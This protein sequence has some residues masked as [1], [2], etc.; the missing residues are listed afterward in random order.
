M[1]ATLNM[2][3]GLPLNVLTSQG[4]S[5][6]WTSSYMNSP[7]AMLPVVRSDQND[8]NLRSSLNASMMRAVRPIW[9]LL[10]LDALMEPAET[11]HTLPKS[12]RPCSMRT[13]S[14]PAVNMQRNPPPSS[15]RAVSWAAMGVPLSVGAGARRAGPAMRSKTAPHPLRGGRRRSPWWRRG[16]SNSGPKQLPGRCLQA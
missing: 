11:P 16:E 4:S 9:R 8:M 2:R 12:Y 5:T 15:T 3:V 14:T 6:F 10:K 7:P 13:S 1:D